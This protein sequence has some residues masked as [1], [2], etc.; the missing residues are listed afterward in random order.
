VGTNTTDTLLG[1]RREEGSGAGDGV[2]TRDIQLGK[3]QSPG[4]YLNPILTMLR[5]YRGEVAASI[6]S[7]GTG[8]TF[9]TMI[10]SVV[11]TLA[12]SSDADTRMRS[13]QWQIGPRGRGRR[14]Q[15]D[16]VAAMLRDNA[17]SATAE[18]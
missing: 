11:R 15:T 13:R 16:Y 7:L 3:Q 1:P 5:T 8:G 12:L 9:G 10:S 17:I 2:R 6:Q 18:R 4:F 14:T